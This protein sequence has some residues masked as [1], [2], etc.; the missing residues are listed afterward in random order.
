MANSIDF[1]QKFL[2]NTKA[3]I[4]A[5]IKLYI[6][7]G[8]KQ[9]A[10]GAVTKMDVTM[11]RGTSNRYQIDSDY[12][13]SIEEIVP[14]KM[15]EISI[16]LSRV[17]LYNGVKSGDENNIGGDWSNVLEK[18]G[19]FLPNGFEIIMQQKPFNIVEKRYNPVAS[20]NGTLTVDEIL[21]YTGCWVTEIPY[22]YDITG[23]WIIIQDLNVVASGV[24]KTK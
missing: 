20:S 13:G 16:R 3:R 15:D 12:P 4:P 5:S 9:Y 18:D 11:R 19:L 2:P 8:T 6:V 21:T 24:E 14:G 1:N 23:D 7:D 10:I 22:G 17:M